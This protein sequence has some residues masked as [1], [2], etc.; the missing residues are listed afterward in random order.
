MDYMKR[1]PARRADAGRSLPSARSVISLAVNYHQP[2]DPKPEGPAGK[3]AQYAYGRDYHR[4]LEKKLKRL[5]RFV[6]E[7]GGPGTE[8]RFYVDTGPM[9]ERAFAREAGLG[10]FGKNTNLITR[11]YGSWVFLACLVTNLKLEFDAPHPGS[12]GSC[13]LC[14]EACPTSAILEGLRVD[15]TRCIS[16]WTIEA[17]Q[18]A[19]SEL[20]AKFGEWAF[21]CDV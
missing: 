9:L 13:T 16:Y 17:K 19:P 14:L 8:T 5:S 4:V 2:E 10:F 15:A 18:P 1:D 20:R 11:E 6:I 7:Q 21:G 3:V 12:C